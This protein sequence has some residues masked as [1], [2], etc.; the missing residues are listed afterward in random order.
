M[1]TLE[2]NDNK[3]AK[4]VAIVAAVGFV[5]LIGWLISNGGIHG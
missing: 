1:S 3:M 2:E 5:I 4:I